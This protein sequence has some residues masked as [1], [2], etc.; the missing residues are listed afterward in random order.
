[1]DR[2]VAYSGTQFAIVYAVCLDDKSPGEVFYDGLKDAD[3]AKL[4]KLFERL[5]DHG[6]ILNEEKFKKIDDTFFEF[7]S[8]Q[9]RMPCFFHR[10]RLVII[11]HGF[12]KKTEKIPPAEIKR[13]ERIKGEDEQNERERCGEV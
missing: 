13:A 10:G 1:M 6:K 3:K 9:I 4:N 5:G 8:F 11:T 12:R 7:K 2:P